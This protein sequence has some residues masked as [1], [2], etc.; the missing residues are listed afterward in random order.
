MERIRDDVAEEIRFHLDM[1]AE[2]LVRRGW[3]TE[4]ARAQAELE[5][6]DVEATGQA[7]RKADERIEGRARRRAWLDGWR[8]DLTFALRTLRRRPGFA[9]V[10]IVTVALGIGATTLVF[11]VVDGVLLRP[12]PYP[13]PDRIVNLWQTNTAWRDAE[14][15][16]LRAFAERFPASYP[17]Y[18][19]WRTLSQAFSAVGAY[20]EE[21]MTATG[22]DRPERLRAVRAS[23]GVF[24]ALAVDP[25]LGRT[26]TPEEDRIGG[27]ALAVLS[28]GLWFRRFG[29]DRSVIGDVVTLDGQP[30]TIV[31]VMPEGFYF[32][33]PEHELWVTF[34]EG[35]RRRGR[36]SQFLR[37]VARLRP[38]VDLAAA[39]RDLA[40]VTR[41]IQ[42][43]YPEAQ[44]DLGARLVPRL[45]EV[46]GHVR[47]SLF[48]L[49]AAAGLVL[50]VACANV[51]NLLLVRGTTRIH[52]IA[53]RAA[54]GAGRTR[55]ARAVFSESIVLSVLGGALGTFGALVSMGPVLAFLPGSIP[56]TGEIGL[57][58]RVLGFVTILTAGTAMIAGAAPALVAAR[59]RVGALLRGTGRSSS[60]GRAATRFRSALVTAELALAFL[61]L[62]SAGLVGRSLARLVAIDPGFDAS[63]VVVLELTPPVDVYPDTAATSSL[64]TSLRD[65]V[66][67]LSGV[68]RVAYAENVPFFGGS[69]SG[70]VYMEDAAREQANVAQAVVSDGYFETLRISVLEGRGFLG[71][72]RADAV[73]AA[74]ISR[75]MAER[76]WPGRNPIGRR[77]RDADE[78]RWRTIVGVVGDVRHASLARTPEPRL[79]LPMAQ[80]G[81]LEERGVIM[82]IRTTEDASGIVSTLRPAIWGVAPDVPIPRVTRLGDRISGSLAEPRFRALLIGSLALLA[83]V[84]AIA[85]VYALVAFSVARREAEL[86]IRVAL[87]AT[88]GRLMRDVI[89]EGLGLSAM[90][91]LIGLAAAL[92][93]TWVLRG[94]LFDV[95]P[96]DPAIFVAAAALIAITVLLA[97]YAPARRAARVDPRGA[98]QA[99]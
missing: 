82:A 31:G 60:A 72:D 78:T 17:V 7:L 12:L 52:E 73:P 21:E 56:R 34:G 47:T 74:V 94:F 53:V 10:A 63:G 28:H 23:A 64:Y 24:D 1:R 19:D 50:V 46:V 3:D 79:Y 33:E 2:E 49:L 14:S 81:D 39:Q 36:G 13:E 30:F 70:T 67:G 58:G 75:T 95:S 93:L 69:S 26:F 88:P 68:E 25:A 5:L 76:Y 48:I 65:R 16:F 9:L 91:L 44:A 37:S 84:L 45:D 8:R 62:V 40:A 55:L 4:R 92:A 99:E 51:A 97:A 29:G 61:L 54:L 87:G 71:T 77:V 42:E 59:S 22:G 35:A 57:D 20:D 43:A 80:A 83:A 96:T 27:P 38:G 89:A 11:T 66:A 6:G 90:G 41:R 32:P 85:G 86:G 98:L 18:E 15:A